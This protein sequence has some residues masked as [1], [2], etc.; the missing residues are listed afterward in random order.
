VVKQ[1]IEE[2]K[3]DFTAAAIRTNSFWANDA[4]FL[5]GLIAYNL[6]KCLRRWG[7]CCCS[8]RPM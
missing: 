6:I 5:A 2:L 7:C 1:V 8:F 3:N 4:L